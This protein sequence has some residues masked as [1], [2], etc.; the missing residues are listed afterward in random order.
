MYFTRNV[1]YAHLTYAIFTLYFTSRIYVVILY[2]YAFV[3]D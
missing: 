1:K 3:G 2:F